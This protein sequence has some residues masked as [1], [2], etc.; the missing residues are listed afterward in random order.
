[1]KSRVTLGST[2]NIVRSIPGAHMPR[3]PAANT[4][5]AEPAAP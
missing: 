1:M 5:A 2:C 3:T 4:T